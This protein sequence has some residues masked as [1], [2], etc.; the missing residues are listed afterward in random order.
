M[1]SCIFYE[2]FVVVAL[3]FPGK[4]TQQNGICLPDKRKKKKQKTNFIYFLQVL[5][6]VESPSLEVFKNPEDGV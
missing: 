1:W 3:K 4:E 6:V 5:G 2:C